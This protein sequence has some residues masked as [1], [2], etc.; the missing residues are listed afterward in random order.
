MSARDYIDAKILIEQPYLLA[1]AVYLR[2]ITDEEL[3]REKAHRDL[4]KKIQIDLE[5]Q[6]KGLSPIYGMTEE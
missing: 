2:P 3:W 6:E 5:R 1:L 4:W